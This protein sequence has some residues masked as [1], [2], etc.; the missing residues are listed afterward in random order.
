M[1]N[2]KG[3]PKFEKSDVRLLGKGPCVKFE[4]GNKKESTLRRVFFSKEERMLHAPFL[5]RIIL[6]FSPRGRMHGI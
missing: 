6:L 2:N 1:G 3:E 5:Q 4:R